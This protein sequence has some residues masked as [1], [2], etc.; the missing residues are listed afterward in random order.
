MQYSEEKYRKTLEGIFNRF[1]SVQKDGFSAG[2]YKPGL[3]R[4]FAFDGLLGSPS[5]KVK[6]V[7]VA[8]TNG[9]GS[10][11]SMIAAGI[12]ASGTRVGLYTSPHLRDFRE[13]IKAVGSEGF[14]MISKEEVFKFLSEWRDTFE[15]L[16]L[17]FFEI[18]T[19]MALWWFAEKKLDYAVIE[20]G[21]G[22]RLDSTN[23]IRPELSVITS[24]GL[25][26]CA[27]LGNTRA[28]IAREK[29]GIFK[30]GVPALV[31]TRDSETA[32]VFEKT[33]GE[34]G[35]FLHFAN[36]VPL[37][38]AS[39]FDLG[40][41]CQ[42]ENLRTACCALNLLGIDCSSPQI[43]AALKRAAALTGLHGRWERLSLRPEIICDIGHNPPAL[44]N[45]FARLCREKR[46]LVI[47]FGVMADKDI[48]GIIP[49][50]P[51]MGLNVAKNGVHYIFC[52]P[53]TPRALP[54]ETLDKKFSQALDSV[55]GQGRAER[56]LTH[57]F[58]GSVSEALSR[59]QELST[60]DSLIYIG[61]STFVL[62]EIPDKFNQ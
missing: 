53:D 8:G 29:A 1:P 30:R 46:P 62:S 16:D 56:I 60:P 24:I 6:F 26:H 40:G 51:G 7:H 18:T 22:G 11:A 15:R 13:R 12:A 43:A 59:A 33:A 19:G 10:V 47:V 4:M 57:E 32:C 2:A 54:A 5:K 61:G 27:L 49:L 48:S 28:E 14:E 41:P 37:P 58:V 45:N 31:G 34:S 38:D 23:I 50:M 44:A 55:Y 17:S 21:L 3:E 20:V 35:A 25:D 52:T 39:E 36:D 9:K 42:D